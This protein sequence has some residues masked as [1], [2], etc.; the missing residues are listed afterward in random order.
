VPAARFVVIG[1]SEPDKA[2]GLGDDDLAAAERAGVTL[3]GA[4]NDVAEWYAA[5]DLFV[6]ASWREGFPRA[7]MEAAAM[8]L[9][10]VATD[11][12]GCRQVVDHG[13]TG[14]LV[15][16]RQPAA[17]ADA[18]ADLVEQP[19]RRARMGPAAAAK[20]RAEFDQR[21][22]IELTLDVYARC[23]QSQPEAIGR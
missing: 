4:R 11:I 6:L 2:D 18:I 16:P 15:P 17:L 19:E 22:Q 21:S 5:F 3:L 14:L 9:P 20:A 13:V 8:G 1:P 23:R 7:A 10:M 12:R